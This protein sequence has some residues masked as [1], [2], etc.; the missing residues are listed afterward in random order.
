MRSRLLLTCVFACLLV[1]AV[2]A[3]GVARTPR[4]ATT[5]PAIPGKDGF[6]ADPKLPD[7][8]VN[9]W[10]TYNLFKGNG[11]HALVRQ[12]N[13]VTE[14]IDGKD[15]FRAMADAIDSASRPVE[16]AKP[17]ITA[18][19]QSKDLTDPIWF[20]EIGLM[21]EG[22]D[23]CLYGT[24]PN[25]GSKNIGTVFKVTPDLKTVTLLHEFDHTSGAG[26]VG[27]LT[28]VGD[29]F[30]GTTWSGG[31]YGLGT[32]FSI[33]PTGSLSTLWDFRN[34]AIIPPPVPPNK[35]TEQQKLDA[36][37]AYPVAAPVASKDGVLYGL[38]SYA[39]NGQGGVLYR[40]TLTG[41]Q[42]FKGNSGYFP[43]SL[44]AGSD[45]NLYGTC[46]KGDATCR[47]GTVFKATTSGGISLLHAF[48]NTNGAR[49]YN[50]I[51]G[52]DGNLYGTTI[53]G[54][55]PSSFAGVLY[56]L[57]TT[58]DYKVL[59][60]FSGGPDGGVPTP[61]LAEGSDGYLYGAAVVGG[62]VPGGRGVLYR[63]KPNGED[64]G[65]CH[66][67]DT[68]NGKNP[69][70]N[71]MV[72]RDRTKTGDDRIYGTTCVGGARYA[73]VI[74]KMTVPRYIYLAGWWLTDSFP[75]RE[76]S[77]NYTVQ[78]MLS[79]ASSKDVQVRAM[80]WN[81]NKDA[82]N[83]R[84]WQFDGQQNI[85]EVAHINGLN[86]GAAIHDDRT[87]NFGSHHQKL[88][89]VAG[90]QG[91][92]AFCGGLDINPDRLYPQGQGFNAR[93]DTAGAPLHDVH[94]RIKGPAAGDLL[95]IFVDRW[96]DHPDHADLDKSKGTL[97][98]APFPMKPEPIKG[99]TSYVQVGRTFGNGT[100]HSGLRSLKPMD[101]AAYTSL[102][103]S[104]YAFASRGE[105][106]AARMIL[107][108]IGQAR[109]FIYIEDQYFVDTAPNA[110][111][112]DVRAALIGALPHIQHLTV[113]IPSDNITVMGNPPSIPNQ[114]SYRRNALIS[115]LKKVGGDK[116]RIFY[117]VS[118]K[119]GI[120]HSYV[121]AKTWIFDDE[122]AIIGS[123]NCNR[124]S[125]THDSEVV[126]GICDQGDG[127][128]CRM[129][130]RLRMRL[131]M[132]HLGLPDTPESRNLVR[133]GVAG[134]QLW[135]NLP[136]K[137]SVMP[138]EQIIPKASPSDYNWNTL[139]D[140]DGS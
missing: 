93:G 57:S 119:N 40:G 80:L 32:I 17:A 133:D 19:Y 15:T 76:G 105:Q 31:K 87:L 83:Q 39:N 136:P 22:A 55:P 63:I 68:A 1:F 122:F 132:E 5:L 26:P 78:N 117:R 24:S 45:G 131:W 116:V 124:R 134:A 41:L 88:L 53:G 137:A 52:K 118:S 98:G 42:L 125:W 36:A 23:G 64:F 71:L 112:L 111:G 109:K 139:I 100:K 47:F 33:T 82:P 90:S 101:S 35:V 102:N 7:A 61:G 44:I 70:T 94:C 38:A 140:P 103:T 12:G 56:R 4:Q 28:R 62:L 46:L 138:Y 86:N 48:D 89:L 92:I 49:P 95:D 14:F 30:Y 123:A 107:Q 27:G 73:G 20:K 72:A 91:L 79:N 8:E 129:P 13:E 69:S 99:A 60:V 58:G 2:L 115:A 43:A 16:T 97:Q 67:F 85:S 77:Q 121:H 104:S 51:Q 21:A 84:L 128:A 81:S 106:S 50:L 9:R 130:H 65:I 74:Y 25:G 110:A 126:V 11:Q 34:G 113:V 10:F 114:V 29:N 3:V 120:P 135:K 59:H 108:A 75:I 127:T 54:G 6:P 18:E 66:V 96:N 37:G